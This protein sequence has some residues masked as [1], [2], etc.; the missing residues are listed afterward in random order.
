[1]ITEIGTV[2]SVMCAAAGGL[3]TVWSARTKRANVMSS[4]DSRELEARRKWQADVARWWSTLRSRLAAQ[5]PEF[6]VTEL[7]EFVPPQQ[8][9]ELKAE[10]QPS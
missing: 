3:I 1:M 6:E 4:L 5:H 9:K 10:E 7:P 2:L 8:P